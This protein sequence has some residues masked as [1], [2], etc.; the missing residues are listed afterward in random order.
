MTAAKDLPLVSISQI[1]ELISPETYQTLGRCD[2]VVTHVAPIHESTN[3]EALSFYVNKRSGD[4]DFLKSTKAGIVICSNRLSYDEAD[5]EEK[6]LVLVDNPRLVFLRI[7]TALFA[8]KRPAGVHSTAV[9]HPSVVLNKNV[10]MGPH[11]TVSMNCEI[12]EGSVIHGQVHIHPKTRIGRN[13]TIDAGTVLGAGGFGFERNEQKV[14]EKFPH[15][16]GVIIG[17]DVEI[18]SNVT[19][20]RGTLGDTVIGDGTKINNLCHIAHN[21]SVGRHCAIN[22]HVYIGGSGRKSAITLGSPQTS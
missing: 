10:Y 14:L 3:R 17:D 8:E 22:A 20:D 12:G 16:G 13:V 2:R 15:I 21:V 19:I 7:V 6:T 11:A 5:W 9:L 4:F 1:I 18:G